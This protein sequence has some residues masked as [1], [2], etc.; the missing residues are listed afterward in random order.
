MYESNLKLA[1]YDPLTFQCVHCEQQ[2]AISDNSLEKLGAEVSDHLTNNHP[3]FLYSERQKR[4]GNEEGCL[5]AQATQ[6]V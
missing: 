1:K 3:E 2:F 6:V 5:R 4:R